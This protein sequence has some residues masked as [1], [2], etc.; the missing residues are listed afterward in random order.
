MKNKKY[1]YNYN[2]KCVICQTDYTTTSY[3]STCC[4]DACKKQALKINK[5]SVYTKEQKDLAIKLRLEGKTNPE[6]QTATGI[7]HSSLKKLFKENNIKLTKEQYD[8]AVIGARWKD[9]NPIQSGTKACSSCKQVLPLINFNND[10]NRLTKLS[11][12]CKQCQRQSYLK[13]PE[14]VKQRISL[15][16]QANP[17]KTRELSA[18]IYERNK[19]IYIDRAKAW[20]T[21]NPEKRREIERKYNAA[22]PGAK[23]AR[24]AEYRA[25][26]IQATPKWL[27]AEQKQ[28]IKEI[29]SKCPK[30]HC[31]DHIIPLRGE[32][33]CGL[34]V[35]WNLQILPARINESKGNSPTYL[36]DQI[37]IGKCFQKT[38]RDLT[39]AE[40]VAA[41][42]PFGL[43]ASDFTFTDEKFSQEH[44]L[45]I[46]RYEWLGTVGFGVRWVF[47]ARYN[48]LLAGVILMSEPT[49]YSSFDKTKEALIQRGACSS[50]APKN[51]NS[52]LV[53]FG[54]K[55]M[56]KNTSKRMFVAYSDPTAGEIGTIYQAC[57]FDYLGHTFGAK[58]NYELPNGKMV[59][60]R[61]FTRTSAVKKWAKDLGIEWDKNWT[62]PNGF[63]DVKAIP[64]EI[65]DIIRQHVN[66]VKSKL[67]QVTVPPKG[68]Y[69]LILGKDRKEQKE[70]NKLKTWKQLAYPKRQLDQE[71]V[72]L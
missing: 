39:E 40:D 49:S 42:M 69:A 66:F 1:I 57:N 5:K 16:R 53:M 12:S 27:T 58:V 51:L 26:K 67:K 43:K 48:G 45:F 21:A 34:H 9:H 32:Q 18:A 70:L 38:R 56:V 20:A 47:T 10:S 50:W 60:G 62:K 22:N 65:R 54:C 14:K 25:K 72:M 64:K 3:N 55:W 36:I 23:A 6:I 28:E 2:K 29:Y 63:Q 31:V 11:P 52:K 30:D 44:R 46:E 35:P 15:Y 68:K 59:G 8:N 33:V 19:D 4:S 17:E 7:I 41:G 37:K 61:H 13:D 24:T 71:L